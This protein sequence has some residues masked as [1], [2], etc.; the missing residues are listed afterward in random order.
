MIHICGDSFGVADPEYG[1]MWAELLEPPITNHCKVAASNLAISLQVDSAI[2]A[3]ADW[4]CVF[5]TSS[6]RASCRIKNEI[7]S[8]SWHTAS[9]T[10]TPFTDSQLHTLKQYYTEFHDLELAIHENK[11]IIESVLSRLEKSGIKYIW[12]QG[13]FEHSSF[14]GRGDY[15]AEYNHTRAA[16]CLWDYARTRDYR[17]YYHITDPAIHREIA[18]YYNGILK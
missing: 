16:I 9:K 17:P 15:F 5:F 2:S 7:F 4:V 11:C 10:T 12:D 6:T 13:G 8:W 14:G 1:T 18:D 3:G